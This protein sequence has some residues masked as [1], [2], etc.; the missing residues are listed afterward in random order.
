M[1]G[2]TAQPVID[3]CDDLPDPV[4]DLLLLSL[5]DDYITEV[6]GDLAGER[7]PHQCVHPATSRAQRHADHAVQV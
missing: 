6:A 3:V 5:V 2:I 7:D 1:L 4:V